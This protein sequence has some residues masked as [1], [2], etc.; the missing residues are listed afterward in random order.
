MKTRNNQ[1]I[2]CY[3]PKYMSKG[4]RNMHKEGES[5]FNCF[6]V[7]GKHTESRTDF[8]KI[9]EKN[10]VYPW[11]SVLPTTVFSV[12]QEK[13]RLLILTA[14][15]SSSCRVTRLYALFK[16]KEKLG[17]SLLKVER[18]TQNRKK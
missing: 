4:L 3:N 9:V 1:D 7:H 17:C 2:R 14:V 12:A 10:E 11:A 8:W 6:S 16:T 5:F 18:K 13:P 15:I